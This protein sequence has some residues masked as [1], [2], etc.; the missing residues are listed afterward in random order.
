[1]VGIRNDFVFVQLEPMLSF[2][3]LMEHGIVARDLIPLSPALWLSTCLFACCLSFLNL[4]YFIQFF[5]LPVCPQFSSLNCK[6]TVFGFV[7]YKRINDMPNVRLRWQPLSCIWK[8]HFLTHALWI[9]NSEQ[10][11]ADSI[12]VT[13]R[14]MRTKDKFN[15][16]KKM[17]QFFPS[18]FVS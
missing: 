18:Y 3:I 14:E 6:I 7:N 12:C 17:R 5:F 9:V 13:R 10:C 11:R 15:I 4:Y 2:P 16:I 1:M 8:I